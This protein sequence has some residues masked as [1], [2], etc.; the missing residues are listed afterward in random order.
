MATLSLLWI[1]RKFVLNKHNLP[2]FTIYGHSMLYHAVL[3][4]V[5]IFRDAENSLIQLGL[6]RLPRPLTRDCRNLATTRPKDDIM[7]AM[8]D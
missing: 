4:A 3:Y 7:A 8:V 2:T 6:A 1:S 5:H